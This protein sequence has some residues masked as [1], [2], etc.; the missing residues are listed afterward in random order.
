MFLPA[1]EVLECGGQRL[2]HQFIA[3]IE[4]FVETTDSNTGLL[5]H[6]GNTDAFETEFAKPPGRNAHDPSVC[7]RLISL[8][9]THLPSPFL[10]ESVWI[11][12]I[13]ALND[14]RTYMGFSATF[15]RNR[16]VRVFGPSTFIDKAETAIEG[17]S[18]DFQEALIGG[19]LIPSPC[20]LLVRQPDTHAAVEL[21]LTE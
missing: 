1:V 10:P 14:V 6:I 8:R 15:K 3:R 18:A 21:R 5:H 2:N 7:L 4:M 20:R 12:P 16:L 17:G 11:A 19:R 9:I 13:V